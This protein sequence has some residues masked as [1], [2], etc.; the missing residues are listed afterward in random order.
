MKEYD[1]IKQTGAWDEELPSGVV[2]G[3]GNGFSR[4]FTDVQVVSSSG[5]N[6]LARAKRDGRWWML[7]ALKEEYR[8]DANYQNLQRKEYDILSQ[9][10]NS[11]VV[12]V[13]GMEPVQ[14]LGECIVM[15]WVDGLTLSQWLAE[16]HSRKERRR[17]AGELLDAVEAVHRQQI[18]HR[19]LKPTNIMITR[20]GQHVKLIDFGLADTDSYAVFKQAAGTERYMSEEQRKGGEAD[21]RNDIYSL[22]LILRQMDLGWEWGRAIKRC[23]LP[24]DQ[25]WPDVAAMRSAVRRTRRTR[26]LLWLL[27]LIAV[28]IGSTAYMTYKAVELPTDKVADFRVGVLRHQSWD[29]HSTS[30]SFARDKQG[31]LYFTDS[32]LSIPGSVEY[33][34]KKWDVG[35]LGFNAFAGDTTL[36]AVHL[37]FSGYGSLMRGCFRG[38]K[39]LRD[40]YFTGTEPPEFGNKIWGCKLLEAFDRQH[41]LQ[42]T[43]HVPKGCADDYRESLWGNFKKI[44]DE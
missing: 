3:D 20:N 38:C 10:A 44:V 18:V 28:V 24:I 19:D 27:P 40:I 12:A 34:G 22:G 16:G 17:I 35:E 26:M 23:L 6:I 8:S 37:H 7:K 32:I 43:L 13:G 4:Q 9:I 15:E 42:T 25:R 30:V 39:R 41:L 31:R 21:S 11:G 5:F 29:G 2:P 36:V 14:G 33:G 1:D